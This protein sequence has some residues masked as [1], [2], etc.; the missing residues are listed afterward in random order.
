MVQEK[1]QHVQMPLIVITSEKEKNNLI[2]T[3]IQS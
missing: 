3:Q 2:L 1:L